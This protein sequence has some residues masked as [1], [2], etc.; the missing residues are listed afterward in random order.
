MS[1]ADTHGLEI[2]PGDRV[3]VTSYGYGARLID[4]GLIGIVIGETA[5][6]VRIEFTELTRSAGGSDRVLGEAF[7]VAGECLAVLRRDE[8]STRQEGNR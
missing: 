2:L 5:K 3:L 7:T 1:H 8:V 4:V 6:R